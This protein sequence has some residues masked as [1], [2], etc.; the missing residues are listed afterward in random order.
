M[1]VKQIS[2]FLENKSGRLAEVTRILG[3]NNIDISALSIADT[4]DFGIL[5]LI[6]NDPETA[7]KV[8]KDNG[9]TVSCCDVIA[10]SVPDKPGGLAKVLSV[11]EPESIGIE[12]LYAFVG[13]AENEALVILRIDSP[14]KAVELLEKAGV[15]VLDS[16]TVYKL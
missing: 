16:K 14:E 7:E 8:L 4:T 5:R 11:L 1:L 3:N 9:F 10:I 6:V 13:K 2:V 15:K 12:Y